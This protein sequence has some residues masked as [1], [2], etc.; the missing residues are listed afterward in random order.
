MPLL[1][2]SGPALVPDSRGAPARSVGASPSGPPSVHLV[3]DGQRLLG[4]AYEQERAFQIAAHER[5]KGVHGDQVPRG[6][7][8]RQLTGLVGEAQA[9]HQAPADHANR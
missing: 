4:F 5:G 7:A 3:A 9:L 6:L 2:A 1:P 8:P